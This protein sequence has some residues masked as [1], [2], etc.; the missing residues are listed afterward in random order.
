MKGTWYQRLILA[1]G[2]ICYPFAINSITFMCYHSM[3]YTLTIYAGVLFY[4]LPILLAD[5]ILYADAAMDMTQDKPDTC[6]KQK[7]RKF[8]R[9]GVAALCGLIILNY[10]WFSNGN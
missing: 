8:L 4:L 7:G 9:F 6:R 3:I 1:A 10:I 5:R 2:L